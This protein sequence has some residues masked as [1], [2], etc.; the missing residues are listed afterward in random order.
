MFDRK[1]Y[2]RQTRKESA[3]RPKA[4]KRTV[5]ESCGKVGYADKEEACT[6][7]STRLKYHTADQTYLRA[8]FHTECQTWHLTHKKPIGSN[9]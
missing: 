4:T 7:A 2:I 1:Q 8:Y 5:L 6:V 3:M 9:S